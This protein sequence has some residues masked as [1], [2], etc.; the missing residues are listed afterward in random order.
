MID[1]KPKCQICGVYCGYSADSGTT[2]GCSD[3]DSPEPFDPD[4]WCKKCAKKEYKRA[5]VEGEKM[6]VYWQMPNWQIKALKKLGLKKVEHK[7]V[8]ALSTLHEKELKGET[9]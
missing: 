5:L 6:Y 4:F 1:T 2:Y 9:K 8:K 7:L 3:Y